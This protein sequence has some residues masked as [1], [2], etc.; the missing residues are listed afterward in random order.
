LASA[1]LPGINLAEV[2]LAE[3]RALAGEHGTAWNQVP[4]ADTRF[5]RTGER[6]GGL[7]SYV[8]RV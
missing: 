2:F 5:A 7:R 1:P 3:F 4:G 6:P 8:S